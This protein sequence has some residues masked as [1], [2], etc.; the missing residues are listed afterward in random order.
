ML[1]AYIIDRIRQEREAEHENGSFVPLR[2]EVPREPTARDDD[3]APEPCQ[4]R[5]SIVIDFN[6]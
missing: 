4:E 5:G 1:D 3:A 6:L 2:I